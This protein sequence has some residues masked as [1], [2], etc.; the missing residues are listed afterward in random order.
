[1]DNRTTDAAWHYHNGTK[2]PNGKLLNAW[3]RF[4]PGLTPLHKLYPELEPI[5]LLPETRPLNTPALV[6]ISTAVAPAGEQVPELGT[7]ARLLYFSAGIT[8]RID[9]GPQ[10]GVAEYRAAA[11]T[12]ALYHIELYVVC[13]D[14]PGLPAGVYHFDPLEPALRQLRAGDYRRALIAASGDEQGIAS[15]PAIVVY[16]DVFARNAEKYQA[17][18]YRHAFW[19]CG[20]IVAHTLAMA[21]ATGLPAR[22]VA[23]FVDEDVNRLLDL[24]PQR[25]YAVALVPVGHTART[26]AAAPAVT[27]LGFE[28]WPPAGEPAPGAEAILAMHAASSLG[29]AGEVSAWRGGTP[30]SPG[31]PATGPLFPLR[32]AAAAEQPGDL[33][34][35]VILRRGSTRRF[36]QATLT[37]GQVSTLLHKGLSAIPADFLEPPGTT[38]T[39]LYAI[40]AAVDGLPP[41]GYVYRRGAQAFELLRTGHLR[42]AARHLALGQE[43]AADAS[44]NIYFTTD[45]ARVLARY[46]NRGYRAA[47]LEAAIAAGRLYLAAYALRL[48]A[49]GL[50]FFDDDVATFFTPH[51]K[52][53]SAMF[54]IALG[55]KAVRR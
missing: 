2:H 55:K 21:A 52:D 31:A 14:L 22:V 28:T 10:V 7:L 17:R 47:Q 39:R 42:A 23:G 35:D 38:L 51:A 45:L 50:T 36:M 34:E 41:G 6:A 40:S 18:A 48:G 27:P 9:Y 37:F 5:P 1:M 30:Q 13:G 44:I 29:T 4:T 24:D 11:C 49:T 53:A 26:A 54:L 16:T 20:T 32:P 8:K 19:D 46:G 33:I 25:E 15:A 43:L 3:H 12:G